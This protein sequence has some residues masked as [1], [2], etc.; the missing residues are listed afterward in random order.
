MSLCLA[1]SRH[2]QAITADNKGVEQLMLKNLGYHGLYRDQDISVSVLLENPLD[3][4]LEAA[5]L[6][7]SVIVRERQNGTANLGM[8]SLS[9]YI[10][11]EQNRIHNM[12]KMSGLRPNIKVAVDD[13]EP[14]RSPDGLIFTDFKP[15]FL[16]QNLRI[17]FYYVPHQQF[18]IIELKIG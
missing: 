6:V 16:F 10:M 12:Q 4:G 8:D 14:V 17:A 1:I 5:A 13:D 3:C 9:F 15:E 18:H 7:F 2:S 11:D